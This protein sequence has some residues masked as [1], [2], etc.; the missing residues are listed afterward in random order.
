MQRKADQLQGDL[1]AALAAKEELQHVEHRCTQLHVR[2]GLRVLC[3][4]VTLPLPYYEKGGWTCGC[5][6]LSV[7]MQ[8]L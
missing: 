1:T 4:R 2:L 3:F 7:L 8:V 5:W 6:I